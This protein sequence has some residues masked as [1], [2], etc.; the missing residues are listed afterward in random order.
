MSR[1]GEAPVPWAAGRGQLAQ[2]EARS[3]GTRG[4]AGDEAGARSAAPSERVAAGREAAGGP[5]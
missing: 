5:L 4:A 1:G 3:A 2:V